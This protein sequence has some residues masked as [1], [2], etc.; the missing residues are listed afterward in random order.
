MEPVIEVR[1]LKKSF[2]DRL[3][4]DNV[5]FTVRGSTTSTALIAV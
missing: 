1:N 4:F 5:S 3:L 2:G